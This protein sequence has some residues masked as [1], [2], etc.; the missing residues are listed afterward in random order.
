MFG[1][2]RDATIYKISKWIGEGSCQQRG[3]KIWSFPFNTFIPL[4]QSEESQTFGQFDDYLHICNN[5]E[6]V[7]IYIQATPYF[8]YSSRI[9][10][11]SALF[12]VVVV[13]FSRRT[14]SQNSRRAIKCMDT[15]H[16]KNIH[17]RN[18]HILKK[19]T[20]IFCVCVH[21]CL[22]KID[23]HHYHGYRTHTTKNIF[24]LVFIFR[25]C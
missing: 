20:N 1:K 10:R 3:K 11:Y 17:T 16:K 22:S 2:G 6:I 8:H 21:V 13:L 24:I 15:L 14:L 25:V 5:D 19:S 7:N 12:V 9:L 18:A 4:R 23:R